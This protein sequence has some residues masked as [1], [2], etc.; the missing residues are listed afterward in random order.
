MP[1]AASLDRTEAVTD[2]AGAVFGRQKAIKDVV[3]VSGY[4][5]IDGQVKTNAGTLFVSFK[6]YEERKKKEMGAPAVLAAVSKGF[7]GIREGVV[8]AMNPPSIPGLGTTGG[9]EFWVQSRG[10]GDTAKIEAVTKDFIAKASKRPELRALSSTIQASS[11]QLRVDV[12]REKTESLGVPVADVYDALQTAFGSLYV[13]QF[14][15]FS[16][17]WQVILQ[18][19]S[20]YRSRPEDIEQIY[21]RS[22][23]GNMVPLKSVVKATYCTGPDLVTRFNGF[24]A[25]KITGDAAPGYSSGQ[26]LAAMEEVASKVLP[27][28]FAYQWSGQSFE[29]KKSGSTSF[30]VFIFG[31][32]MVFLILAAQYEKW[33]LPFGVL[34][35][36]PFAIF[37]AL[38]SVWLRGIDNDVYF[39]IGLTTLIALAAKN[40]I[41]ITEFAVMK[42]KEGLS[43]VDAAVEA[44]RLRLRPI[45][46]TSLAFILGCVPLAI[47]TGASSNSRHSIGTGVIGG[48]LGATLIA[49]FFIPLFF[50]LLEGASERLSSKKVTKAPPG[51]SARAG[52]GKK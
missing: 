50:R 34:M 27:R 14:N 46:M 51:E 29:E 44:A 26:A 38:L 23:K 32:I 9:F 20:K 8:L 1:D 28:D 6:D 2:R 36:V 31:L 49:V 52:E 18:A 40:A 12:D 42:H 17:L 22:V 4:S 21:V 16:R 30:F 24:P 25:A 19:E 15:K 33:S 10:E 7:G 41:L 35:A 13:S 43:V 39:Q 5:L 47:A 11:R 3:T 37:G 45:V 48:M